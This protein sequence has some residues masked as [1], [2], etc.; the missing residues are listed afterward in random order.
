MIS[1]QKVCIVLFG[2]YLTRIVASRLL[3]PAGSQGHFKNRRPTKTSGSSVVVPLPI[4]AKSVFTESE[5][6][7]SGIKAVTQSGPLS[8]E[9]KTP[10]SNTK[11]IPPSTV[12]GEG[13]RN[14]LVGMS[15]C[16]DSYSD[17][18]SQT[19]STS[20][21]Q[22]K[23][24][25]LVLDLLFDS[26]ST[27]KSVN[28]EKVMET[29][30]PQSQDVRK[31]SVVPKNPAPVSEDDKIRIQM[32]QEEAERLAYE[33]EQQLKREDAKRFREMEV[34]SVTR[35]GMED[36][37]TAKVVVNQP[38]E[39][40]PKPS[41]PVVNITASASAKAAESSHPRVQPK[42]GLPRRPPG[43][44]NFYRVVPEEE[45]SSY[46]SRRTSVDR[47]D[48]T[49]D[50][51]EV[52]NDRYEMP[53][54]RGVRRGGHESFDRRIQTEDRDR[55]ERKS[56]NDDR[57]GTDRRFPTGDRDKMKKQQPNDTQEKSENRYS[58]RPRESDRFRKWST[59]RNS[60]SDRT[61]RAGYE[62]VDSSSHS[63]SSNSN[64][65]TRQTTK[66]SKQS[67]QENSEFFLEGPD[68]DQ[69]ISNQLKWKS[70]PVTREYHILENGVLDVGVDL[71][72][73]VEIPTSEH[74]EEKSGKK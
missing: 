9:S 63:F 53:D 55:M 47:R 64:H 22:S 26:R 74:I 23:D 51:R 44:T 16:L 37:G 67:Q 13:T 61:N 54:R 14:F 43:D 71:D 38:T 5:I 41:I 25:A 36:Y 28:V 59:D 60:H 52:P 39:E 21:V 65:S 68:Y 56:V 11:K 66:P 18:D 69:Y 72:V 70:I 24:I 12:W 6:E 10:D 4:K 49:A 3:R 29:P 31:L 30:L 42:R 7:S 20:E 50:R 57:E 35:Q 17:E 1:L 62:T 45:P 58:S 27:S 34:A 48:V 46:G 2:S 15:K 33:R 19:E 73:P 32:K 8:K 40:P